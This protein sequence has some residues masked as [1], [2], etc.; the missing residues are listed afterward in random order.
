[1]SPSDLEDQIYSD[2]FV[3][4]RLTLASGDQVIIESS[5]RVLMTG[6][7]IH[8]LLTDDPAARV[9]TRVRIVSI[10]NIVLVEPVNT[11]HR[12]NGRKRR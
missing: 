11:H 12:R 2:P 10:P 4:L 7:T 9:G 6:L 8:Y 1:M 5:Q 3:P